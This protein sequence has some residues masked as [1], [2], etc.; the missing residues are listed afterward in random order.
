MRRYTS[1]LVVLAGLAAMLTLAISTL[2]RPS[3][4]HP[5]SLMNLLLFAAMLALFFVQMRL[6]LVFPHAAITGRIA[7]N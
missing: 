3:A 1:V 2:P 5:S 4:K 7:P 6:V